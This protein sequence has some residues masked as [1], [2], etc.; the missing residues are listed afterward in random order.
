MTKRRFHKMRSP[1][2]WRSN[3]PV[4]CPTPPDL[5]SP[6]LT[7]DSLRRQSERRSPGLP[8]DLRCTQ[9]HRPGRTDSQHLFFF[10]SSARVHSFFPIFGIDQKLA[11]V[12]APRPH[13]QKNHKKITE[14][15]SCCWSRKMDGSGGRLTLAPPPRPP[16]VSIFGTAH[17]HNPLP[18]TATTLP[19]PHIAYHSIGHGVYFCGLAS[20]DGGSQTGILVVGSIFGT[21]PSSLPPKHISFLH[22]VGYLGIDGLGW[23]YRKHVVFSDL[24]A[25]LFFPS[26]VSFACPL[27]ASI[28]S[29]WN[30]NSLSFPILDS[31]KVLPCLMM[32]SQYVAK[33]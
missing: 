14:V 21:T 12:G 22:S 18:S 17:G 26:S 20:G 32:M 13:T 1:K 29:K 33:Y 24:V 8:D 30:D 4:I 27:L 23:A 3:R 11:R 16:L 15:G 7:R 31:N 25:F 10:S 5:V 28:K 2:S 6:N 9:E 19:I